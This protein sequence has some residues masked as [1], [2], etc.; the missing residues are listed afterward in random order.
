MTSVSHANSLTSSTHE[1]SGTRTPWSPEAEQAVLGAILMDADAGIKAVELLEDTAFYR[2]QHRR[3]FRAFAKLIERGGVVDPVVLRDELERSGD[4]ERAGG[5]DYI[6]ELLD[7]VP[8]AANIEYH[9]RIVKEK[10]LLRRLIDVGTGI[11]RTAYEGHEE[12]GNLLDEAEQQVFELSFQRGTQEVVRIKELMWLAMER[13]ESRH[14]GD[15]SVRGISSGFTDLDEMTNGFQKSDLIIV[16]ARPSMGKTA[17]CLNTA[18]NAALEGNIPV[19]IFSLE[20]SRDQLVERLLA[21]E[22][23]VDLQRLRSGKLRDDDYPKMSRAAGLLGTAPLWIDD[24]PALTLLE[25]RSKAR[26]MKAE[27]DIGLIIIDY[28]QLIRGSARHENRQE[29][30][31][32]ISRS[33]KALARELQMPVIAL[34]QLSRAPEQRGGDRRPV[35]SDLRDSGAI[36]QDADLVLFIYRA[37]MYL[38]LLEKNDGIEE[39]VAELILAKHRNGPTGSMKLSFHKQYTR[40]D[41]YTSRKQDEFDVP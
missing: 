3:I 21:A 31:S 16:A 14:R 39:G 34:S 36:E 38:N 23:F 4:L 30:I 40:F 12:V 15:E 17:F 18:A 37:E 20:M 22:S 13:I 35:L 19:A 6:A 27:H 5:T 41:N 9:C 1:L 10:S 26:R 33:L 24:S 28:L 32:F 7:V 8:T 2:E 25:I 29:E 11:V